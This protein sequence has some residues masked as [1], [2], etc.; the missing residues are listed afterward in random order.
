[1]NKH[2]SDFLLA[3]VETYSDV[4]DEIARAN[5]WSGNSLTLEN[6]T[7]VD[8]DLH[9]LVLEV[10]LKKRDAKQLELRTVQVSVRADPVPS[11]SKRVRAL[12]PQVGDDDPDR[13]PID[14]FVRRLC[15]LAWMAD[16]PE[17]TGKLLQLAMQLG[18][19]GVGKL[20]ENMFLN[21]VPHN[22]Y[23]RQYFYDRA[24]E[25]VL[26]AVTMCSRGKLSNRMKVVSQFPEMN[27]S[28][29]SYRIG[30]IL[31]MVR[32]I[33]IKL[34]EQNVRVR[35]C[36]QGSMGVGIFTGV[37]KQLNGV[38]KLVQM[39]DWQSEPGE[40][41][42]GMVGNYVNFGA[43]GPE[44]VVDEV[45]TTKSETT[46]ETEIVQHQDDVFLLI[47]PQSMVGT[48]SSIMPSLQGMV[49]AAGD[50]PVILLNPDLTD[51]V[52]S[53]GQQ[54]VRGRQQRIDFADSF[55]TV[56]QFRNIYVSGTS[57]FPILGAI[58]KLRPTEPWVA[59]Q[60][61]DYV[62]GGGGSGGSDGEIYVPVLCSETQPSGEEILR[63]FEK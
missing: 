13:L 43:I 5:A 30:T 20:P 53:G 10:S 27:P 26:E 4:G 22:R 61:R 55:R 19:G 29:D 38:S 1:L 31:E 58:T 16:F 24:A 12:L 11:K 45:R 21:Q 14:D 6:A 35:I 28:M 50:R 41:N 17:L 37:P 32:A 57:Y 42:E 51:K 54:S 3:L 59:H 2:H 39:M 49:D 40:Q 15:R 33:A 46:G 52:S 18:G 47:A 23:V 63:T 25:A 44:H 34:A 36:V 8:L 48:D 9:N 56:F 62:G 60:R 7:I